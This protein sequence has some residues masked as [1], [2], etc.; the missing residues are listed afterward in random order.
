MPLILEHTDTSSDVS[1]VFF[2]FHAFQLMHPTQQ[3]EYAPCFEQD[4]QQVE[5]ADSN[6]AS[7]FC[8]SHEIGSE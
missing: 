5:A 4:P 1:N 8:D 2:S 3:G 6:G 7:S